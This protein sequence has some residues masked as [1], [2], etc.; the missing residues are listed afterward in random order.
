MLAIVLDLKSVIYSLTNV[1][2]ERQKILGLVSKKL[3]D[4]AATLSNINLARVTK[5]FQVIGTPDGEV[6]GSPDPTVLPDFAGRRN[7]DEQLAMIRT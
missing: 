5:P 6:C 2:P 3:P 7:S 1:P 4:D